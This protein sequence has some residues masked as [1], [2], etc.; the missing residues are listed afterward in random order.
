MAKFVRT[1]QR[2]VAPGCGSEASRGGGK[3]LCSN[4]EKKAPQVLLKLNSELKQK[5]QAL[6]TSRAVCQGCVGSDVEA[7]S[8]CNRDCSNLY[9]RHF[10][11]E[12][13]MKTVIQLEHLEGLCDKLV[14]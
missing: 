3:V 10:A 6:E 12:A 4:C 1:Q 14:W 7:N 11:G 13:V 9:T 2:C 5:L 8:C